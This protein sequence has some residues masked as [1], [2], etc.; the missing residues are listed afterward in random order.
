MSRPLKPARL[1]LEPARRRPD[2]KLRPAV[3]VILDRG[4]KRSTGCGEN[5]RAGAEAVFEQYLAEKRVGDIENPERGRDPTQVYVADAIGLYRREKIEPRL[6]DRRLREFNARAENLLAGL[7]TLTLD[8]VDGGMC[9]RYA[10]S[11]RA[12][13]AARRELEDLRAAINHYCKRK[14]IPCPA[15]IE[16]PEK[17]LARDRWLSRSEAA[18]LLWAAWRMRQTWKGRE[19]DRA[20]GKHLARFILVG[21]YSGTRHTAIC[22]AGFERT[23]GRGHVD[24]D[25]GIFYR[26]AL[27]ALKTKKRQP[28][29]RLPP[30]L[31]AHLR[32]WKRLG[33]SVG[34]VV[35]WRGKPVT[36]INK[37]FRTARRL[38]GLRD[39]VVPHTL[40]HTCGTWIAMSGTAKG[41]DAA[42]FLGITEEVF[43]RVYGHHRPDHQ[44]AAVA[45][46]SF[47][48]LANVCERKRETKQARKSNKIDAVR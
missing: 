37:S 42:E 12:D 11:R 23:I 5:D 43:D 47:K 18:R 34:A 45:S 7:G 39:D 20:T 15:E 28:P 35:E 4:A 27:G 31:L 48:P 8:Q 19:S 14:H 22:N 6:F 24:L 40:R 41:R 33:I 30:R 17:G 46:F 2:G 10:R 44:A 9:S 1:W 36:K 13:A 25:H 3:Y 21:L 38:A 16:L 32:R 29:V 26:A